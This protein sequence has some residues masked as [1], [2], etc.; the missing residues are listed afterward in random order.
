[1]SKA[2]SAG[3]LPAN[4]CCQD[5]GAPSGVPNDSVV[6]YQPSGVSYSYGRS[7]LTAETFL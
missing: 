2:G 6:R 7:F 5:G 1:L 3:I 4:N